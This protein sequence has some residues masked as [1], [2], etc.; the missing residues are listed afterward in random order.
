MMRRFEGTIALVGLV[1]CGLDTFGVTPGSTDG[2]GSEVIS[3]SED[4]AEPTTP[5]APDTTEVIGASTGGT[6]ETSGTADDVMSGA[7]TANSDGMETT[8]S[9]AAST[10]SSGTATDTGEVCAAGTILCDGDTS[11]TCDGAGGFSEEEFCADGCVDGVG[12]QQQMCERTFMHCSGYP[13]IM[14]LLDASSSTLNLQSGL[15]RAQEGEGAWEEI[16][17]ALAG[18]D[19]LFDQMLTGGLFD[20]I[21]YVGLAVF[22][23]NM[24]DESE[25]LV[26]YG[27]CRK[28]NIAWALD[29]ASSCVGPGCVDPYADAPITWTFRDGSLVSPFFATSTIS[30]MPLCNVGQQPNKG[31]FGSGTYTHLGLL[32]VQANLT[33]YKAQCE[34]GGPEQCEGFT[35][36][37]NI[38]ITDGQTNSTQAQ[39]EAPLME[40]YAQGVTTYVIGYGAGVDT[41]AAIAT[42]NQ[43]ADVGSGGTLDYYDANNPGQLAQALYTIVEGLA[44]LLC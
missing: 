25:I 34:M 22:G 38:L 7:D 17:E 9:G 5:A 3:G 33:A 2:G 4:P 30:H 36:F 41:P 14:V 23:G 12:C 26:Q 29:P 27:A 39:Y 32:T 15:V 43:M 10:T 24:P 13:R 44:Y 21:A 1:G 6:V 8:S 20:Q 40:M 42:L 28:P 31:C 16:R 37:V 18:A 11:K 19:S 35:Q